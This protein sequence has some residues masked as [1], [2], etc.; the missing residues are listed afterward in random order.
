M[1]FRFRRRVGLGPFRVNL[2]KSGISLS[3][4]VPG[5]TVNAPLASDEQQHHHRPQTKTPR[6][7]SDLASGNVVPCWNAASSSGWPAILRRMS[8]MRRLS[9]VRSRRIADGDA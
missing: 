3:A 8:R 9:R 4:G 5:L 6:Q 1:G 7:R 2:S